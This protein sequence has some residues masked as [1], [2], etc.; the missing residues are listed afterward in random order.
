M[1]VSKLRRVFENLWE[2][3]KETIRSIWNQLSKLQES[4]EDRARKELYS[5]VTERWHP[6]KDMR[7]PHQVMS[8]KPR[9]AVRKIIR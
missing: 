8:N 9:F 4:P 2:S 6:P 3:L 5:I 7:K 1:I